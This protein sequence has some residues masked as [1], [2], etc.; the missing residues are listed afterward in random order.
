MIHTVNRLGTGHKPIDDRP[1]ANIRGYNSRWQRA[2]AAYLSS[3]P[4][5]VS[6]EADGLITRASVVDHITPHKGDYE[7]FW[8]SDNWQALCADCHNVK[9][10]KGF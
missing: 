10:G 4:L 8:L 9:T 5:C 6:C 7:L 3:H 1:S 2:R